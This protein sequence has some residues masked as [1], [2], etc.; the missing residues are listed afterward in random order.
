M[1]P[2]FCGPLVESAVPQTTLS[3][4][5]KKPEE[6]P[7]QLFMLVLCCLVLIQLTVEM[8]FEL[9]PEAHEILLRV[10][11]LIC[12]FFF[13]DF[14]V[15]FYQAPSKLRYFFT[16][17]W[18]DLLS[19]IPL[20]SG[21]LWGRA[22]RALRLF[23]IL[24]GIRSARE[25]IRYLAAHRRTEGA[26]LSLVLI[27]VVVVTTASIIVLEF[28]AG[29]GGTIQTAT[30]A[31]WWSVVTMST[32]GYGD[33]YPVSAGGRLVAVA[34]MGVGI[35]LFGTFTALVASWFVAPIEAE[36]E[37]EMET[38]RKEVQEVR[39]LLA[40]YL[41]VERESSAAL[42]PDAGNAPSDGIPG[43]P[44]FNPERASRARR[45]LEGSRR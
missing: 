21:A 32:V 10:D 3:A 42:G 37:R 28:E 38:I 24:R 41:G 9:S 19:S 31:L 14:C 30:D 26:L 16:W 36:Q 34:L 23:K 15:Q 43:G 12:A 1:S 13:I 45:I 2:R 5:R 33:T 11:L 22:A 35:G 7:Y 18:I 44:S 6:S 25:L 29:G 4:K 39:R 8:L 17:G 40:E 27:S 20:V